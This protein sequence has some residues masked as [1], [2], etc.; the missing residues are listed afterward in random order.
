MRNLDQVAR[1]G[2]F[3]KIWNRSFDCGAFDCS[4]T[5]RADEFETMF[6]AL[7]FSLPNA[8]KRKCSR[9]LHRIARLDLLLN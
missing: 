3:D 2:R 4:T 6:F 9:R 8:G 5:T 1:E 7:L